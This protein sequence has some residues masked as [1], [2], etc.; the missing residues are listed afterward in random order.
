MA[1]QVAT[2]TFEANARRSFTR[3]LGSTAYYGAEF[4]ELAHNDVREMMTGCMRLV[5]DCQCV[6]SGPVT[7]VTEIEYVYGLDHVPAPVSR[8][9]LTLAAYILRPTNRPIGAT[10][11]S[12]E[13]G[14]IHFT[15]AGRDGATDVPEVNAAI[16]QYG[17]SPR[18]MR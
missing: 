5:S 10:G 4:V 11:E 14:Y 16:A 15:T 13:G 3:R 9:V 2:E 8:A 1:R 17:R 18:C 12:T 7:G 6:P